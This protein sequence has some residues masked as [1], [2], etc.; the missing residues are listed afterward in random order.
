MTTTLPSRTFQ[1]F[2]FLKKKIR[3]SFFFL[4]YRAFPEYAACEVIAIPAKYDFKPYAYGFQKDSPYLPLFNHYLKDMRE[5]GSLNQILK[6][7]EA[8]PQV[9]PDSSGLPLGFD[10]CFTAF[11]LL[12]GTSIKIYVKSILPT[13]LST[14]P[15]FAVTRCGS[16]K[17]SLSIRFYVKLI[18]ENF[19]VLKRM[20]FLSFLGL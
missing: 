7:Y 19:E 16:F 10:S 1:S 15:I 6:K 8:A 20:P 17:I 14:W 9:C 12:I 11:L 13:V 3:F 4:A 18:L 5:K 2:L